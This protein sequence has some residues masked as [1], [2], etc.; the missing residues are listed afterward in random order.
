M[1]AEGNISPSEAPGHGIVWA[2]G[3]RKEFGTDL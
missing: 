1:D 3:A 2:D